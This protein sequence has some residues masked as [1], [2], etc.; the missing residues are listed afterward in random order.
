MAENFLLL[1]PFLRLEAT[2]GGTYKLP[3]Y[4]RIWDLYLN[5]LIEV[6]IAIQKEQDTLPL[7]YAQGA[8][9]SVR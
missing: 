4:F 7:F 1:P 3:L 8:E 9:K 6:V 2:V 5:V